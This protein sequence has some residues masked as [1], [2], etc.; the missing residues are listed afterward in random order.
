VRDHSED[1][2]VDGR[3]L[4]KLGLRVIGLQLMDCIHLAQ[5]RYR[6]QAVVY[7]VMN[8]LVP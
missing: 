8:L 5:V 3:T 1:L 2:G 4:L 6:F 7:T